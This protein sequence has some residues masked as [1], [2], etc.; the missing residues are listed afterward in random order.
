MSPALPLALIVGLGA[1]ALLHGYWGLGGLWP[2]KDEATLAALVIGRTPGGRMPPPA[3]CFGVCLAILAGVGLTAAVSFASLAPPLSLLLLV[4][5]AVF[6]AVF[7]LRG[8]A[9]YVPAIWRRSAGTPFVRLNTRYYSPLCLLLGA[10]LVL[11]G[12]WRV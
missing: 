12:A 9:G 6:T 4:A 11:N 5:Y 8:V 2:A 7:V 10:G 1:I 3:A